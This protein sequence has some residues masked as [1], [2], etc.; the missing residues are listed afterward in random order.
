MPQDGRDDFAT[1]CTRELSGEGLTGAELYHEIQRGAKKLGRLMGRLKRTV[2]PNE[3][4]SG[5]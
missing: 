2:L 4:R 5:W 3:G 1:G